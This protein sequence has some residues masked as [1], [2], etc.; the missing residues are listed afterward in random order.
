MAGSPTRIQPSSRGGAP[1]ALSAPSAAVPNRIAVNVMA[2]RQP[3][4]FFGLHSSCVEYAEEGDILYKTMCTDL[5]FNK[6]GV[7][8]VLSFPTAVGKYLAGQL[9]RAYVSL[10]NT[11]SFP[12]LRVQVRADVVSPSN[13]RAILLEREWQSVDGGA[14]RDLQVEYKLAEEGEYVLMISVS[15]YESVTDMPKRFTPSYRFAVGRAF[16]EVSRR[17][18][19]LLCLACRAAPLVLNPLTPEVL[20][21]SLTPSLQGWTEITE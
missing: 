5:R 6:C 21:R 14:N 1:A 3:E 7:S 12:L 4:M 18:S 9:L 17:V 10:H 19:P 15:Y 8:P 13:Q 20:C 2:L 16:V 11:V